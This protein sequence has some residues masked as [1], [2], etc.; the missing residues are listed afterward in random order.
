[1]GEEKKKAKKATSIPLC[2]EYDNGQWG[3]I[4]GSPPEGVKSHIKP[5]LFKSESD[6][7]NRIRQL[8]TIM[9]RREVKL[10]KAT[11]RSLP[12]GL[13]AYRNK[14]TNQRFAFDSEKRSR[15]EAFCRMLHANGDF[16]ARSAI[17]KVLATVLSGYFIRAAV[18]E[19]AVY[20]SYPIAQEVGAPYMYIKG[21]A[22]DGVLRLRDI[23][24][25][26]MVSTAGEDEIFSVHAP[27][28]LHKL[29]NA[30]IDCLA[31]LEIKDKDYKGYKWPA[32]YC[33]TSVFLDRFSK[34]EVDKFLN[35][36]PWC[37]GIIYGLYGRKYVHPF[38]LEVEIQDNKV[39]DEIE[40]N[41]NVE[42]VNIF[43]QAYVAYI[44]K[45]FFEQGSFLD[46]WKAA[47]EYFAIPIEYGYGEQKRRK[48]AEEFKNRILL[49]GLLGLVKFIEESGVAKKEEA[50]ALKEIF[51]TTICPDYHIG[52]DG[53]V[54]PP[55]KE[56]TFRQ[57]IETIITT[58]N[59][60]YFYPITNRGRVWP[61]KTSDGEKIW[62]YVRKYGNNKT[63][64]KEINVVILR[65]VL[66]TRPSGPIWAAILSSGTVWTGQT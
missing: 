29:E 18:K 39:L 19:Q 26:V 27:L 49:T 57:A 11:V 34:S 38:R 62:G 36:N 17:V 15:F 61:K 45:N 53:E 50:E 54:A 31:Y 8:G 51:V 33:D 1:M 60:K 65:D 16:D 46:I 5:V 55:P 32:P 13:S 40:V 47:G 10:K 48:T 37:A 7:D 30:K 9:E 12:V 6:L 56:P 64:L 24:A 2:W 41:W 21:G 58:E 42:Q 22:G 35:R 66:I 63:A 44:S 14:Y 25:S 20:L 4:L 59:L 43:I 28:L 3:L 52:E 23:C